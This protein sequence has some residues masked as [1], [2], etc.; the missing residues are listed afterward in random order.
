VF[1][2]TVLNAA[3]CAIFPL[4]FSFLSGKK[5]RVYP[6]L[7]IWAVIAIMF[8]V[9]AAYVVVLIWRLALRSRGVKLNVP[10]PAPDPVLIN[11]NVEFVKDSV[12]TSQIIDKM[13]ISNTPGQEI[14]HDDIKIFINKAFDCLNGGDPVEA[15][16]YFYYAI[17]QH[18]PLYLEIQIVIQLSMVYSELGR[19]DLSL[20]I[21][22]E[23][24]E[25]YRNIL[26][27]SDMAALMAGVSIIESM[28]AS[29]GGDGN[30]EN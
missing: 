6:T 25:K 14:R 20:D 13:G 26:S 29:I 2:L 4:M 9:T 16:E 8:L 24:I 19:A 11:D 28:L 12:D 21:M 15:A 3:F 10:L 1:L 23:Y 18:P 17:T 22:N 30:E 7:E 27:D 5:G